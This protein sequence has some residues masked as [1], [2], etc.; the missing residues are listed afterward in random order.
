MLNKLNMMK[1]LNNNLEK[2]NKILDSKCRSYFNQST[3]SKYEQKISKM[4][5]IIKIK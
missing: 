5:L 2:K 3:R 1:D 4:K